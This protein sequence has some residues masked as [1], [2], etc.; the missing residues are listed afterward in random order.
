AAKRL[1]AYVVADGS[2]QPSQLRAHASTML[3]DYMVPSTFVLLD[4]LPLNANGKLD[5]RSLP[6]P[7]WAGNTAGYVAPRTAT[8]LMVARIWAEVLGVERVGIKDNFF[9]LGGDSISSIRVASRLRAAFEVE[10]S[11]RLIFAHSTIAAVAAALPALPAGSG[12]L[13]GISVIPRRRETTPFSTQQSFAQQRLW[14]LHAFEP[15]SAEY[16]TRVGLRLRGELNVDALRA[17]FTA[18]VAR[19]ESLRTTFEEA[20]GRGVQVVHPP[21]PVLL[22]VLDLPGLDQPDRSAELE[23]VLAAE[24]NEPF[25]LNAGP[26][27]RARL[28]RLSAGDHA[29]VLVL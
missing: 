29:L 12:A 25:D 18:L 24:G 8:E 26:L 22:P 7:E 15:D 17:A 5:R 20:D 3:P 9:E 13:M 6:A 27:M 11:P 4:H 23:S 14:F 19:H 2:A 16:A 28:V 1:V 21:Q 10:L